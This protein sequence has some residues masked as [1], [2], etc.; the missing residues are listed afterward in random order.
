MPKD[1][2]KSEITNNDVKSV[3]APKPKEVMVTFDRWFV[4]T[5]KPA[6]WKAGMQS[7]AS[8]A[9]KKTVAVWNKIFQNY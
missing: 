2:K 8:T 4:A 1:Y 9:G 6:H 5:N 7:Y 3:E